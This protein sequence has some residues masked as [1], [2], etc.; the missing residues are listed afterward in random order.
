MLNN[1]EAYRKRMGISLKELADSA[2]LS[3]ADVFM[4]ETGERA[5]RLSEACKIADA[6][7]QSLDYLF[8]RGA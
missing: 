2:G 6:L 8:P 1:I 5:A 7:N 4:I 3:E